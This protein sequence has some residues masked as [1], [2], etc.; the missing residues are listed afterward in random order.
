LNTIFLTILISFL[1]SCEKQ[2]R[3][4]DRISQILIHVE[5]T[6]S[7]SYSIHIS[8]DSIQT[9]IN[10]KRF[11]LAKG[12]FKQFIKDLNQ[13][14][15]RDNPYEAWS[16]FPSTLFLEFAEKKYYIHH[17]PA[18]LEDILFKYLNYKEILKTN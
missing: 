17:E 3:I 16:N 15:L 1:F 9:N 14:D 2:N 4:P 12:K 11:I 10:I 8:R 7:S 13:L 6:Q 18:I 5:K